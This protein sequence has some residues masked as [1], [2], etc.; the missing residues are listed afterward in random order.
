MT[1]PASL[2]VAVLTALSIVGCFW[3]IWWT[4]RDRTPT[5]DPEGTVTKTGHVW[6]G[7]LEELNNP[8]PRWWLW[9]FVITLIF[10][11]AYLTFYPGMGNFAGTGQW[12]SASAYEHEVAQQRARFENS[13]AGLKGKSIAELAADPSAMATGGNLFGQN[14]AA[15]HGSDA[16]GA[17]GYP[18]LADSD[19]LWGGSDEQIYETIANGR[20]GV[21][22]PW[23]AA[24][25]DDGVN[26]VAAYVVS[27][28]GTKAPADW[29][30]AG[31]PRYDTMCIGCHGPDARGNPA[32]GA[33]DL[34]DRTWLHGGDCAAVVQ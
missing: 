3:R 23:Q 1:Q 6:D 2:F 30:T 5:K 28:S 16:R 33:P 19:W 17:R 15:C 27:L 21:M 34:T 12:S 7:D 26:E 8:L 9:L 25:G 31:K 10:G 18:N 20:H 11:A 32:L 13:M 29:V 22:P 4:S 14:C 24:L